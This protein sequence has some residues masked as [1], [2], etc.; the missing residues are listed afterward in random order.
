MDPIVLRLN[1]K[2]FKAVKKGMRVSSGKF[3]SRV[4][5]TQ[6]PIPALPA[7]AER[8]WTSYRLSPGLSLRIQKMGVVRAPS[9]RGHGND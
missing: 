9:S 4:R 1:A 7:P 5:Q 3:G 6:I 8:S 2:L